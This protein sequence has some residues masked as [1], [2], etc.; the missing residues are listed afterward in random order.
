[1]DKKDSAEIF[2]ILDKLDCKIDKLDDKLDVQNET[3]LRN[4]LSL[5]EHIRRTVQ[6]EEMIELL[7]NDLKPVEDHV[8]YV[9]GA[10]KLLG[11]IALLAG[12]LKTFGAI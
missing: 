3:T 4:T 9:H 11:L 6:N 1:M 2:K 5:E 8:K 7:R 10:L 12:L